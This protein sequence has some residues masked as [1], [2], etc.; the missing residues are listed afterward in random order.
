MKTSKHSVLIVLFT[1]FVVLLTACSPK[2][3]TAESP[4]APKAAETTQQSAADIS[5]SLAKLGFHVFPEAVVLPTFTVPALKTSEGQDALDSA[6]LAGK[7]TLLNFWATWCPPCKK[8][9]PSIQRLEEIMKGT[10]FR[11]AAVSTGE[12]RKTVEDFIAKTAYTFPVYLD[13]SGSL[14]ASFASQGIP[15]TYII[16]KSGKIYA[17][18]V[19][20]TEY[21]S[22]ELLTVLKAMAAQ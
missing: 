14:G 12:K 4:A 13:E 2:A 15:T 17:G 22:P 18:I 6:K 19:G 5:S 3:V 9:M 20:S 1:S 16:D 10:D 11:I 7:V 8:E 21:D